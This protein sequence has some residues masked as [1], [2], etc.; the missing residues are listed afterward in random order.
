MSLH[1]K[2][3]SLGID[4]ED[5]IGSMAGGRS[6]GL[7]LLGSNVR[8]GDRIGIVSRRRENPVRS[9]A[10]ARRFSRIGSSTGTECL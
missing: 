10:F 2:E 4:V 3:G 5:P 9:N 8:A 1:R 6:S 7:A